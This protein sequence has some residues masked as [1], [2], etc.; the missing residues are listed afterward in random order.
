[1]V[2]PIKNRAALKVRGLTYSIPADWADMPAPQIMV[3]AIIIKLPLGLD[4][5]TLC[6]SIIVS[7]VV[8]NDYSIHKKHQNVKKTLNPAIIKITGLFLQPVFKT[9]I[10]NGRGQ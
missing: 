5:L 4:F 1:M 7:F 10:I 9:C 6:G 8:N 3:A 2:P